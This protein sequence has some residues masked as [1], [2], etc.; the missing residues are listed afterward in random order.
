MKQFLAIIAILCLTTAAIVIPSSKAKAQTTLT[1]TSTAGVTK[2]TNTNTDTGYHYIDLAGNNNNFASLVFV[3]KGTKT[4]GT[5]GGS[6]IMYGSVDNSRWFHLTPDAG[7][8]TVTFA[9]S[10]ND[11]YWQFNGTTGT[12][13]K[14]RYYRVV[15]KTSGTQVSTYSVKVL[16]RKVAN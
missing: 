5:V 11:A 10:D 9:N 13:S 14:W 7:S 2:T 1:Q 6:A 15:V 16:G 8:D 12:A 4:S 3:L